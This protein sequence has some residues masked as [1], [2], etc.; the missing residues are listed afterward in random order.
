M[1]IINGKQMVIGQLNG[2]WT[3]LDIQFMP[4]SGSGLLAL[5]S[6]FLSELD[7]KKLSEM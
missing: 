4:P 6:F 5:D 7:N 2:V 3:T 1:I